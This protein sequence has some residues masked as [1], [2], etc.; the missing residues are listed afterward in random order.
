MFLLQAAAAAT[1]YLAS[2]YC[3]GPRCMVGNLKQPFESIEMCNKAREAVVKG[4]KLPQSHP[5][6]ETEAPEYIDIVCT[7][8]SGGDPQGSPE[9]GQAF[10]N[11]VMKNYGPKSKAEVP[12][13]EPSAP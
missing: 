8:W 12:N 11:H 4:E 6:S 13:M 3:E 10:A 1:F 5:G 2:V 7:E 9:V